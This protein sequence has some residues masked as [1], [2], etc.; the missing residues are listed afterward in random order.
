MLDYMLEEPCEREDELFCIECDELLTVSKCG[1]IKC[2]S[3]SKV[4]QWEDFGPDYVFDESIC[5]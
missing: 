4:F 2:E 5:F 1:E 3:C